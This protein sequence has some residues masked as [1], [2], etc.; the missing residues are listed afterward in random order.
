MTET[1]QFRSPPRTLRWTRHDN[2]ALVPATYFPIEKSGSKRRTRCLMGQSLL[3]FQQIIAGRS[4]LCLPWLSF[5]GKKGVTSAFAWPR[6][7]R[8]HISDPGP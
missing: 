7:I 2:L 6:L 5:W 3:C 4:K 1:Q 8:V